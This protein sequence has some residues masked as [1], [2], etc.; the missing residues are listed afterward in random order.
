M[1]ISSGCLAGILTHD[2]FPSHLLN[3][4]FVADLPR[5]YIHTAIRHDLA[6]LQM[7]FTPL[8]MTGGLPP[9]FT[10]TEGR[11]LLWL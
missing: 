7:F 1:R 3:F 10:P 5:D 6:L 4:Y 2:P 8:G 9:N 11:V